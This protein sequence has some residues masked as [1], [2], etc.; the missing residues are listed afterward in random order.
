M[1]KTYYQLAK[2]GIIYGN[3]LTAAAG[4]FLAERGT[5]NWILFFLML[6][7]LSLVIASACI[8]NNYIDRDIDRLMERTKHR[9]LACGTVSGSAAL[10]SAALACLAGSALLFFF[11][12]SAA[13]CAALAGVF[14]YIVLYSLWSKRAT[15]SGTMIGAVSGALPPVIGY[16]AVTGRIDLTACILFAILFFWQ[17]PH[18]YA[19]AIRRIDDYRSAGIPVLPLARSI[20][21]AKIQM[22]AYILGFAGA[23]YALAF[24]E[25]LGIA[26]R[27]T[28]ALLAL[29][30]IGL[31]LL[32]FSAR[33]ATRWARTMFLFSLIVIV[34][35]SC[36][37]S[38]SPLLP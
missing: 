18:A 3:A 21:R 37:T 35:W 7:G 2:P 26:Y 30:W 36:V 20:R 10:I 8:A 4:F 33:D 12:T 5:V 13:L 16:S 38:L 32:G 11:T 29:A 34:V 28:V 22:L 23:V 9:A 15:Q 19:I 14:F 25:H 24:R 17:M 27:S 1:L 31:A 6:A